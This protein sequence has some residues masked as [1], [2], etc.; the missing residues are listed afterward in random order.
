MQQISITGANGR[1]IEVPFV[2][3]KNSD[4]VVR[5]VTAIPP[6]K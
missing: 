4:N 3:I 1:I 2:W 6:K 5:L